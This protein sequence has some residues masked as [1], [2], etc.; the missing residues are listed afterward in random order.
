MSDFDPNRLRW[1]DLFTGVFPAAAGNQFTETPTAVPYQIVN[2]RSPGLPESW[3][4]F[5]FTSIDRFPLGGTNIIVTFNVVIGVGASPVTFQYAFGFGPGLNAGGVTTNPY[6][7]D[8]GTG[9]PLFGWKELVVPARDLQINARVT[10]TGLI[11]PTNTQVGAWAA[12]RVPAVA[13]AHPSEHQ[14]MGSGFHPEG[15]HYK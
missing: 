13:P 2:A 15:L 7:T 12:P 10:G 6:E 11:I 9:G 4:I 14:W 3:T 8:S 5:L 1:G